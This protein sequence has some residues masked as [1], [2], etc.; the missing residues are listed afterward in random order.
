MYQPLRIFQ[1]IKYLRTRLPFKTISLRT[2]FISAAM[3][4]RSRVNPA[5]VSTNVKTRDIWK[6]ISIRKCHVSNNS[7]I[8]SL[9]LRN[10]STAWTASNW[11]IKIP[12]SLSCEHIEL[13]LYVARTISFNR[14]AISLSTMLKV[15]KVAMHSVEVTFIYKRRKSYAQW[16]CLLVFFHLIPLMLNSFLAWAHLKRRLFSR[17]WWRERERRGNRLSQLHNRRPRCK[18]HLTSQI[19]NSLA[20]CRVKR[21]PASLTNGHWQMLVSEDSGAWSSTPSHSTFVP[22]GSVVASVSVILVE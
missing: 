22:R 11:K 5:L 2:I 12:Q 9:S 15:K 6:K 20:L 19:H 17:R 3:F 7:S 16:T 13:L 14:P 21:H 8:F 18:A 10:L 4:G 1:I